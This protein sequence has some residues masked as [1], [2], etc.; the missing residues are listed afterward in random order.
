LL[1]LELLRAKGLKR[2]KFLTETDLADSTPFLKSTF[3]ST[4]PSATTK[5][6]PFENAYWRWTLQLHIFA[7]STNPN[8]DKLDHKLESLETR[9]VWRYISLE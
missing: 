8:N 1:P 3:S 6:I 9:P 2:S 5:E 4:L 7:Q